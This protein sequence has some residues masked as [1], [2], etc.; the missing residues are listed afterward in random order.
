MIKRSYGLLMYRIRDERLEVFLVHPGG[1]FWKNKDTGA[2]S[3]PK[4]ESDE[5]EDL[6]E[7]AKREFEE[8]IGENP[9]KNNT[10]YIDLGEIRQKTGK[11]VHAWAFEGDWKGPLR[12]QS[13]FELEWPPRSG[14]KIEVPEVDKAEFFNIEEAK[15]KIIS[16][17][18]ELIE[19]LEIILN[20]KAY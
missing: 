18:A 17:Q 4:G 13:F 11:I 12:C 16:A 8:E 10:A 9:P 15:A 5:N 7:T 3:I 2:W 20:A 14:K 1:P 6:L 19:R